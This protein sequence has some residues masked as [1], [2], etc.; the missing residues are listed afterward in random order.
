MENLELTKKTLKQMDNR[1]KYLKQT[2]GRNTAYDFRPETYEDASRTE[3][4]ASIKQAKADVDLISFVLKSTEN[5]NLDVSERARLESIQGRNLSHILLNNHRYRKDSDEMVKIKEAVAEV[6]RAIVEPMGQNLKESEEASKSRERSRR[7]V[8]VEL[9]YQDAILA[10]EKYLRLRTPGSPKGQERYNLVKAQQEH[11]LKEIN[12]LSLAKQLVYRGELGHRTANVK[13]LLVEAKT[14]SMAHYD[15]TPEQREAFIKKDGHGDTFGGVGQ[16]ISTNRNDLT[17]EADLLYSAVSQEQLPDALVTALGKGDKEKKR[18]RS[19]LKALREA[20]SKFKEN[21]RD[22]VSILVEGTVV[23]IFQKEDNTLDFGFSMKKTVVDN[24]ESMAD[25]RQ[26]NLNISAKQLLSKL[27]ENMVQHEDI[28]G[29]DNTAEIMKKLPAVNAATP[30]DEKMRA[31]DIA[32]AYLRKRLGFTNVELTNVPHDYRIMIA[33]GVARGM[34]PVK[35]AIDD[36]RNFEYSGQKAELREKRKAKVSKLSKE[37]RNMD[38]LAQADGYKDME[39]MLREAETE[40]LEKERAEEAEKEKKEK[41]KVRKAYEAEGFEVIDKEEEKQKE[42]QKQAQDK[43]KKEQ[44]ELQNKLDQVVIPG[45]ALQFEENQRAFLEQGIDAQ[46]EANKKKIEAEYKEKKTALEKSE[47]MK[48][49]RAKFKQLDR[50]IIGNIMRSKPHEDEEEKAIKLK[51]EEMGRIADEMEEEFEKTVAPIDEKL[52]SY[53]ELKRRVDSFAFEREKLRETYDRMIREQTEGKETKEQE[54]LSRKLEEEYD[55]AGAALE[56]RNEEDRKELKAREEENIRLQAEREK[57]VSENEK[58]QGQLAVDMRKWIE[59]RET[60]YRRTPEGKDRTRREKRIEKFRVELDALDAQISSERHAMELTRDEAMQ[61][62]LQDA[63]VRKASVEKDL[64]DIASWKDYYRLTKVLKPGEEPLSFFKWLENREKEEQKKREEEKEAA[65][66][67]ERRKAFLEKYLDMKLDLKELKEKDFETM[68]DK[69]VNGEDTLD[70]IRYRNKCEKDGTLDKK[71]VYAEKEEKRREDETLAEDESKVAKSTL[72][73]EQ[74]TAQIETMKKE[75]GDSDARLDAIAEERAKLGTEIARLTRVTEERGRQKEKRKEI[76]AEKAD[77]ILA[78]VEK[79]IPKPGEGSEDAYN[80]CLAEKDALFD[81]WY[82]QEISLEE[83]EDGKAAADE[84]YKEKLRGLGITTGEALVNARNIY[85]NDIHKTSDEVLEDIFLPEEKEE[86]DKYV[87]EHKAEAERKFAERKQEICKEFL[88]GYLAGYKKKIAEIVRGAEEKKNGEIAEFEHRHSEGKL[89]PEYLEKNRERI[90]KEHQGVLDA[91]KGLEDAFMEHPE[92]GLLE[93]IDLMT[94]FEAEMAAF[95]KEELEKKGKKLTPTKR[96]LAEIDI[97]KRYSDKMKELVSKAVAEEKKNEEEDRKAEDELSEAVAA[98]LALQEEEETIRTKKVDLNVAMNALVR[99][100]DVARQEV[101]EKTEEIEKIREKQKQRQAEK[102]REKAKHEAAVSR[103]EA[104]TS[105]EAEILEILADIVYSKE[106]WEMDMEMKPGQRILNIIKKHSAL[107][108]RMISFPTTFDDMMEKFVGKLPLDAMGLNKE[109][110]VGVNAETGEKA[111]ITGMLHTIREMARTMFTEKKKEA[112]ERE[113]KREGIRAEKRAWLEQRIKERADKRAAMRARR[114]EELAKKAEEEK[115]KAVSRKEEEERRRYELE[116]PVDLDAVGEQILAEE[117]RKKQEEQK[118]NLNSFKNAFSFFGGIL[119]EESPEEKRKREIEEEEQQWADEDEIEDEAD[120]Q[121]V[122]AE[123]EQELKDEDLFEDLED[124]KKLVDTDADTAMSGFFLAA[125]AI[126]GSIDADDPRIADIAKYEKEFGVKLHKQLRSMEKTMKKYIQK[127]FGGSSKEEK[128]D[129]VE[130]YREDGIPKEERDRRIKAGK[131]QLKK[132]MNNAMKGN[133]G[134]GQFVRNVLS[135]YLSES[136]VL[137]LRSMLSSAIRN[138]KPAKAE[139]NA[140]EEEKNRALSSF[141]GG[142]FKGAGPLLQKILQGMGADMIPPGLE[143]AFEDMKDN[144]ADIPA[145]IVQAQLLAMIERSDG[146]IGRIEIVKSLG[147]ASVGQAFLCKMYRPGGTYGEQVV[148]K[149]L[150][151]DVR[152]R[153]LREKKIME[154]CAK[155]AG[156][157]MEKTYA[158]QMQR[159]IE[160]LDL[161]IEAR[162]CEGGM[163]YNDPD[164]GVVAMKVERRVNPTPN[165]LMVQQAEGDTVTSTIKKSRAKREELMGDLY[166][167][168]EEG[169]IVM[170]E[171]DKAKINVKPGMDVQEIKA[172]LSQHLKVLQKEQRMLCKLAKKWV[173]EAVFREDGFYHGDLH[174]GNI[175]ISENKLTVIDFGNA[176][177]LTEFE[178]INV[179]KMLMAAAAGSGS[180]FMEGFVPLLGKDSQEL[181]KTKEKELKAIFSEVMHLGD[182]NSSAERIAAALVRAQKLG[183][184]LPQSIYGFEQCQIRVQNTIDDFNRE[185]KEVQN[186]LRSLAD[187]QNNSVLGFKAEYE[188]VSA[189]DVFVKNVMKQAFLPEDDEEFRLLLQNRDEKA[190]K[191]LDDIMGDELDSLKTATEFDDETLAQQLFSAYG[192]E[193]K[194]LVD[195]KLDI[196]PRQEWVD[197]LKSVIPDMDIVDSKKGL[198]QV[199]RDKAKNERIAGIDPAKRA[200][201]AQKIKALMK[202]YDILGAMHRLRKAQDEGKAPEELKVLEDEAIATFRRAKR[203]YADYTKKRI[204]E[205]E[206]AAYQDLLDD[207]NM[208]KESLSD[209][210]NL[211]ESESDAQ[212]YYNVAGSGPA[213]QTAFNEYKLAVQNGSAD[214]QQKLDAFLEAYR[215]ASG[216]AKEQ[217]DGK[218]TMEDKIKEET[219]PFDPEKVMASSKEKLKDEKNLAQA[220][221]EFSELY[222]TPIFGEK[223]KAAFEAYKLAVL[224][225][226]DD[227]EQKLDEL[228][229]A[230]RVPAVMALGVTMK[231]TKEIEV[232]YDAPDNFVDVMCSVINDEYKKALKRLNS[233]TKTA[234]YGYRVQSDKEGHNL[235]AK[236]T[237]NMIKELIFN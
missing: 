96:R 171:E 63:E 231:A 113:E 220:E 173:V 161:T 149:L 18:A 14:Y 10:C 82:A 132:M 106:T 80:A 29:E 8:D 68:T 81:R 25:F 142:A 228:L 110:L 34:L 137:D 174:G 109:E 221:M 158:G 33:R 55:K 166:E 229:K 202:S 40:E 66:R 225:K 183:F 42:E 111:L 89:K 21:T 168:D 84:R 22:C 175:M 20:L 38:I 105:D 95:E 224:N 197:T 116:T 184:E 203:M 2:E 119:W 91:I 180:G 179:T 155:N 127:N 43:K 31:S 217:E 27:E 191:V 213:L 4:K 123:I 104:W 163:V 70:L 169:N 178:Q 101:E 64:V 100:K 87:A 6:E 152:N 77:R 65:F 140:S 12:L 141:I 50:A 133:E 200:E 201:A 121:L 35:D 205:T 117:E 148:I 138:A 3:A 13:D 85:E 74:A 230:Y 53:R 58:K 190:R 1:V 60:E 192:S 49:R 198:I 36:L 234:K 223:L 93:K 188:R 112:L 108:G 120:R 103:G 185:I 187:A 41:D 233:Y 165:A 118:K 19:I 37:M 177:K 143:E 147:A 76:P 129:P 39:D 204:E 162:N 212:K 128:I 5:F 32:T 61:K 16:S 237:Y 45:E 46:I 157:G 122:E 135:S 83:F 125:P 164:A 150:R 79:L 124:D 193:Y 97:L 44:D 232:D 199:G 57:L 139:E 145:E 181:L 98:E 23:N 107:L 219:E 207:W 216:A 59:D 17:K 126:I 176:T 26:E 52:E 24:G 235:S 196:L 215:V 209:E 236:E 67:K 170:E 210:D 15:V 211:E 226:T 99:Q 62:M 136:S 222:K 73:I 47:L 86:R 214:K 160:E 208:T 131:E 206:G 227:V 195:T 28:F 72:L 159:Y 9:K 54:E 172:Q 115:K 153:M 90:D 92:L 78:Y 102:D 194:F 130:L 182:Y 134:E 218:K 7:L 56:E 167:R 186:A 189:K 151:P 154:K 69:N 94:G 51:Y 156:K 71:V 75:I 88:L 48:T 144:L 30:I 146:K 114:P 11:L